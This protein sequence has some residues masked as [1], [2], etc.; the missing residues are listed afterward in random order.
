VKSF[1][2]PWN[3]RRRAELA[4]Y[5]DETCGENA[6]LR[7]SVESLLRVH[8]AEGGVLTERDETSNGIFEVPIREGSELAS[9]TALKR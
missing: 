2:R 1:A 7:Q 4:A 8:E 9:F 5:L 3:T 6:A